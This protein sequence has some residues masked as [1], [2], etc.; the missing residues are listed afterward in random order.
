MTGHSHWLEPT[1]T[2]YNTLITQE[3]LQKL[4]L[5]EG[6]NAATPSS[7]NQIL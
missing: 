5:Q 7:P 2:K 3:V 4:R 6:K 1:T